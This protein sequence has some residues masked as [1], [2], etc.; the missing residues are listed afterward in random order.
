MSKKKKPQIKKLK[1]PLW[2][3]IG[4]YILTIIVPLVLVMVEGYKSPSTG[5]KWTFGIISGLVL[6]W[7]FVDKFVIAN[8]KTKIQ[9]RKS[10]LEHD[11]EIDVGN[12]DKIKYI[13]FT[14]EQ[15]LAIFETIHIALWGALLCIVLTAIAN[16]IML[17]KGALMMIAI[18]Y[19]AAY[20]LKFIAITIQKGGENYE[21]DE[22]SG[23]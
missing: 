23:T 12:P 8:L 5:F 9:D 15:K 20:A 16:G 1:Y 2:F 10:K 11:Y 7:S 6:L 13:W 14:N 22:Q 18:C 17:I 19:V 21:D 4:F 3:Q